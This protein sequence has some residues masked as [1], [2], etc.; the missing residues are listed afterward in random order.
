MKL[1]RFLSLT[2]ALL[3][4]FGMMLLTEAS[5]VAVRTLLT[6]RNVAQPTN[7]LIRRSMPSRA[8]RLNCP[9]AFPRRMSATWRS[10]SPWQPIM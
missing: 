1:K 8:G 3:L 10:M 4:L 9:K 6:R 7:E 2:M 5:A